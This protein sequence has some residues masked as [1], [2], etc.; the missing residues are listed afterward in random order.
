M[1][2]IEK[3]Y[4]KCSCSFDNQFWVNHIL[5]ENNGNLEV[6]CS[7]CGKLWQ[8][9]YSGGD[10]AIKELPKKLYFVTAIHNPYLT[11]DENAS[12]AQIMGQTWGI[13][14][15]IDLA[16]KCVLENPGD[17]YSYGKYNMAVIE[18]STFGCFPFSSSNE[19]WFKVLPQFE[20]KND[21]VLVSY[22]IKEVE[23]PKELSGITNW[24][25]DSKDEEDQK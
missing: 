22:V 6:H 16:K 24:C 14:E 18:E 10:L 4:F 19:F 21:E 9:V 17:M 5:R 13:F 15:N 25:F 12:E 11:F 1:Q 20:E 23:K 2:I 8:G 3:Q 7:H